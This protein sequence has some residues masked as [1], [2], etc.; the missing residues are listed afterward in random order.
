MIT[1]YLFRCG[2]LIPRSKAIEG[3]KPGQMA[4]S[5]SVHCITGMMLEISKRLQKNFVFSEEWAKSQTS[6]YSVADQKTLVSL[7]S[8]SFRPCVVRTR[9]KSHTKN[10]VQHEFE[11]FDNSLMKNW[12]RPEKQVVEVR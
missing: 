4:R 2:F 9:L 3:G 6:F 1:V 11:D 8:S 7:N 5:V 12:E 10:G